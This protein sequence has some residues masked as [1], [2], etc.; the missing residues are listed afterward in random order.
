MKTVHEVSLGIIANV[1]A[2]LEQ[3]IET[4]E[5]WWPTKKRGTN[6]TRAFN[7]LIARARMMTE[8]A[9]ETIDG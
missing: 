3:D 6:A 4:L 7:S 9:K 1:R 8:I 2:G 5:R